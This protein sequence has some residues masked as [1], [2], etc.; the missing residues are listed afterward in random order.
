MEEG[1]RGMDGRWVFCTE[2]KVRA[3]F[4]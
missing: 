2:R 4:G 3:P 1:V